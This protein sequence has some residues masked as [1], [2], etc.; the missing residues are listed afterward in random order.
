[1]LSLNE[2]TTHIRACLKH[3]PTPADIAAHFGYSR[4]YLSRWFQRQTGISMRDYIA[5]LKIEQ[6]IEPLIEG[7]SIIESQLEAGHAS[8][9]TYSQRFHYHTGQTPR[10]YRNQAE[11]AS[12]T[13]NKQITDAVPRAIPHYSFDPKKHPQTHSLNISVSGAS[14]YSVAFAGL[15][16]EPIPRGVPIV[17]KALFHTRHFSICNVPDGVYYLL[18][19][20]IKPGLNPLHHFRLDHCL[21]GIHPDPICF[22]L[23]APL[24]ITLNLRPFQPSD[25]PITVNLPKLLFD[26]IKAQG[27]P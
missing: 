15:F 1:M 27:N 19:C 12:S 20:E 14:Q 2:V 18:G 22:P 10:D 3:N 7:K 17:G 9:G 6:G 24:A 16:P 26:V 25:P 4:F 5:A 23:S 13:L 8:A 11:A 21:R